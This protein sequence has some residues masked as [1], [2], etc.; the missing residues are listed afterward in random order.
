[1]FDFIQ[2]N[3]KAALVRDGRE[4]SYR[5]LDNRIAEFAERL[6]TH[7]V[8]PGSAVSIESDFCP[9][10]I[11]WFFALTRKKCVIVPLS[12]SGASSS[13]LRATALVEHRIV[14]C[15]FSAGGTIVD[16]PIQ[17]KSEV[18]TLY[19]QLHRRDHAGLVL[20]SSGSTGSPKA[21]VHDLQP[22]FERFQTPGRPYRSIAFLLFDHIGG[23]NTMLYILSSGGCLVAVPDRRPE[24]VLA[25]VE[26]HRVELLPASPTFLNMILL[27]DACQDYDLSSLKVVSYGTEPMAR[28]TLLRFHQLFPDVRLRQ[29]YGLSE[30][31]IPKT[32]SKAS[33]SLWLKIGGEGVETK[34]VDGV[35]HIRSKTAMLGYLNAPSPFGEDGWLNTGDAVEVDG[36]YF[37]FLGRRD[38][39]INV[40]G[41]KVYP[42][43]VEN[44]LMQMPAIADATVYGEKNLLTGAIVCAKVLLHAGYQNVDAAEMRREIREFCQ[45][46]LAKYKIPVKI[47]FVE[48]LTATDRFKKK[49]SGN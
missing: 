13:G 33:D 27:S 32:K 47:V 20:F 8:A 24:T 7:G 18:P 34:V 29:T 45:K 38:E 25:A 37:R 35:L 21:A 15:G 11:A 4:Y 42:P 16:E 48:T 40:G 36:E 19:Q 46:K 30:I 5:W 44:M 10:A 39:M 2:F 26:K 14:D 3:E 41:E 6:A 31:G 22:L 1:M 17:P 9:N 28:S 43:E 12:A 23:I 49:R